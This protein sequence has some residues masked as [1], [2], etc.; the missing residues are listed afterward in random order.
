MLGAFESE[1][2]QLFKLYQEFNVKYSEDLKAFYTLNGA[3][4]KVKEPSI[5]VYYHDMLVAKN[6]PKFKHFEGSN[7]TELEEFVFQKSLPIVGFTSPHNRILAFDKI[8]P[9]CYLIFDIDVELRSHIVSVRD[10]LV[11]LALKFKQ[12]TFVMANQ[13]DNLELEKRLHLDK[14]NNDVNFACVN[15]KSKLFLF[16]EDSDDLDSEELS[17]FVKKVFNGKMKPYWRSE[18]APKENKKL[19]RKV[20]GSTFQSFID[21]P[22]KEIFVVFCKESDV[23]KFD[24]LLTEFAKKYAAKKFLVGVVDVEKNDYSDLFEIDQSKPQLYFVPSYEK[25]APKLLFGDMSMLLEKGFPVTLDSLAKVVEE[26]FLAKKDKKDE[27]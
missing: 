7:I 24:A 22:N 19:V 8:K 26:N 15:Q 14:R 2:D 20:V 11:P 6:Q 10:K 25:T 17:D 16:D 13:S 5:L 1:N 4:F 3:E 9:I 23:G 21:T 18:K 27:L 12:V